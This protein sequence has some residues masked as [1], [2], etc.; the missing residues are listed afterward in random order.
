MGKARLHVFFLLFLMSSYFCKS[1]NQ[2]TQ[3][4]SLSLGDML[5]YEGRAFALGFFSPTNSSKNVYLGIWYHSI[6]KCTVVWVANRDSP[7]SNHSSVKLTIAN[8][9][10]MV[11]FD[12]EGRA[13]WMTANTAT[14]RGAE[15]AVAVLL[16]SGNF[17]LRLLNGTVVWPS[18]DHS[19]DTV[20]P[21]TEV[22]LSYKAQV[23]GPRLVA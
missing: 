6:P 22:L 11:L 19:T 7:I 17:V 12:S 9:S 23:A 21:S 4:N 8:G 5:I 1:N 10:E 18:I 14:A 16:D 15:G 2:I 20:L 13:V 3:A